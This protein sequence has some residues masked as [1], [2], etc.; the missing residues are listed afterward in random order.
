MKHVSFVATILIAFLIF[1]VAGGTLLNVVMLNENKGP[2]YSSID[3]S[4]ILSSSSL[5]IDLNNPNPNG[6]QNNVT[7][8]TDS[9]N[10]LLVVPDVASGCTDTIIV[11]NFC[12]DDSRVSTLS[13]PRDTCVVD[14]RGN[15]EKINSIYAA[16]GI[17][18]LCSSIKQLT[19]IDINYYFVLTIETVRS[20][21]DYLD[22]VYYNLPVDLYY[23]D[24]TQNLYINLKAGFQLFDGAKAEQLLRFR[25]YNDWYHPTQEQLEYYSGS[26]MNRIRTQIDFMKQTFVQKFTLKY[27]SNINSILSVFMENTDANISADMIMSILSDTIQ[28][29]DGSLDFSNNMFSFYLG[30]D[31]E[32]RYS[33]VYDK[34]I[35]F[36]I[37]NDT[38]CGNDG[39]VY[40]SD[41]IVMLL[42]LNDK[43]SVSN[44]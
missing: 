6:G 7:N 29:Y 40:T 39:K 23:Q 35:Y 28:A 32:Y 4:Q 5:D 25:G 19:A 13:I 30:G 41:K 2:T 11:V 8:V 31:T 3:I 33:S 12:P 20:I 10:I 44:K 18:E 1:A 27:L 38:I 37:P 43:E 42:F 14:P 21:I 15:L 24:P 26:D 16:Y 34:E 36:W 9:Y 17:E 22:G